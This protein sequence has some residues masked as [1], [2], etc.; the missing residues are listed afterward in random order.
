LK[1][2]LA[3]IFHRCSQP[4]RQGLRLNIHGRPGVCLAHLGLLVLCRAGA[5]KMRG[6]SSPQALER[7]T[8]LIPTFSAARRRTSDGRNCAR[9]S[10]CLWLTEG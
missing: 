9:Q 7:Y 1:A 8:L 10:V 6:E 2:A 3:E 4:I 5:M